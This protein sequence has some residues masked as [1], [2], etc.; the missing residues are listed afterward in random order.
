MMVL[1]ANGNGSWDTGN[2][3]QHLQPEDV[4]YYPNSI[5]LKKFSDITLTWNVYETP[6][7]KQKPEQIKRNKPEDRNTKLKKQEKKNNDEDEEEDEFNSNGFINNSS[8][9]GDKYKDVK[10]G[11]V[12]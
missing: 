10:R 5:K 11:V 7:D 2:Y 3:N 12:K 8:Y 6:V 9:S 1:D 4:F